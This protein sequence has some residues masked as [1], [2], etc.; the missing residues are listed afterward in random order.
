MQKQR[1][2]TF[3]LTAF[4]AIGVLTPAYSA[5]I[6]TYDSSTQSLFN[7]LVQNTATIAFDDQLAGPNNY[8]LK[9]DANGFLLGPAGNLVQFLGIDHTGTYYT[10]ITWF[11]GNQKDWGTNAV[12]ESERVQHGCESPLTYRAPERRCHGFLAQPDDL[13]ARRVNLSFWRKL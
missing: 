8:K 6:T 11:P 3:I 1:I 5:T 2:H 13:G 4:G 12:L 9:T 10:N 7:T